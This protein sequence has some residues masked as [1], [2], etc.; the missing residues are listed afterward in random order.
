MDKRSR[1][2]LRAP[3]P[4]SIVALIALVFAMTGTAFA[5]GTLVNG[6][7]LIKKSTLSGNRLRPHTVTGKQVDLS[8][9]GKVPSAVRADSAA[10]SGAAAGDLTGTYPAPAIASGAV[11][12]AELGTFPG[13]SVSRG[14]WQT[15]PSGTRTPILFTVESRNVGALFDV[16]TP[17]RL[18]APIAG[19]YLITATVNW[20]ASSTGQRFIGIYLNSGGPCALV[21]SPAE[22]MGTDGTWQ[23]TLVVRQ[24]AAGDY[25]TLE[26]YQDSGAPTSVRAASGAGSISPVLSMDWIGN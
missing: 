5:A 21:M 18:T 11:G 26:A 15:I 20:Q 7:K 6:D 23:T 10:P 4:A 16:G 3:S 19:K 8:K 1:L 13:A 9:L 25:V 2:R 17:T 22:D 14:M 24:L 12:E